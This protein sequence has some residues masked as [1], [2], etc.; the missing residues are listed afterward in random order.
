MLDEDMDQYIHDNTDDEFS[1]VAFINAYL[2]AHG[3]ANG[4]LDRFGPCRAARRRALRR[5]GRLTNLMQL[6]VDT[7]FWP[8]YRSHTS[9][10]DLGDT[11]R[12]AVPTLAVGQHPAIPRND[13]DLEDP[14]HLEAI[15]NTAGFHFA[16]IEQGGTSLYAA[17]A[18]RRPQGSAANP[19]QHR[20]QRDHALPDLARQG[21]QRPS[22][23]RRRTGVPRP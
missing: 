17:L 8:R 14:N 9:S 18:Q 21:R 19:A 4:H 3:E 23:D 10:P 1:H 13:G 12:Q 5:L 6:S 7:S 11:L 16:F 15:A 22:A 2:K 20:R